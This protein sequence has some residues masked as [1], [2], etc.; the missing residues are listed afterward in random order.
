VVQP[1]ESDEEAKYISSLVDLDVALKTRQRPRV[2]KK[3]KPVVQK[4]TNRE[5][6]LSRKDLM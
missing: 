2:L 3:K 5:V 6:H 4:Q 1:N